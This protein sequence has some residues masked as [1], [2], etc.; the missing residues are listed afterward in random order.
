M[1]TTFPA[2]TLFRS[3]PL[4]L[5]SSL[6]NALSGVARVFLDSVAAVLLE[7]ARR[8]PAIRGLRGQRYRSDRCRRGVK[9][10]AIRQ[11]VDACARGAIGIFGPGPARITVQIH[12]A[13]PIRD[14]RRSGHIA[15]PLLGPV[16]AV[17]F[18][19]ARRVPNLCGLFTHL[20]GRNRYRGRVKLL[21]IRERIDA[22]ARSAVAIAHPDR[23][24]GVRMRIDLARPIRDST[25]DDD[26]LAHGFRDGRFGVRG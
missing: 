1:P 8:V 10:L 15:R 26:V 23:R 16:T 4:E 25:G 3:V 2:G 19:A 14:A 24:R 20:D 17:L 18:I 7:A 6:P 21:A 12:F 13:L 22:R 5:F 11:W 9:L